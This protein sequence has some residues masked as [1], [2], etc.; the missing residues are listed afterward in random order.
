MA[1]ITLSDWRAFLDPRVHTRVCS[2]TPL[3]LHDDPSGVGFSRICVSGPC[4]P[5]WVLLGL[6][7]ACFHQGAHGTGRDNEHGCSLH[8]CGQDV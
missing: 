6:K 8:S 3:Q 4:I 1:K 5:I 2:G 7:G